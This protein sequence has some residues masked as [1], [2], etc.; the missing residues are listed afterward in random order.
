MLVKRVWT[1]MIFVATVAGQE[2]NGSLTGTIVDAVD[3]PIPQ[4]VVT[5]LGVTSIEAKANASGDFVL[6]GLAPG[7]YT[8]QFHSPGFLTRDVATTVVAG[9]ERSLGRIVLSLPEVLGCLQTLTG[10]IIDKK[11]ERGSKPILSGRLHDAKGLNLK[12]ATVKLQIAETSQVIAIA[13]TDENGTFY[14]PDVGSQVYNLYFEGF[15]VSGLQ[16]RRNHAAKVSVTV[17]QHEICL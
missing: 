1:A 16:V 3:S 10:Q 8:L 7:V 11:L 14:F 4:A 5:V 13:K 15:L 9:R 2:G 17:P 6:T 12:N